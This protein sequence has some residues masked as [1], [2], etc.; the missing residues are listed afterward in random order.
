M[1][2]KEAWSIISANLALLYSIRKELLQRGEG[3]KGYTDADLEAEV[4]CFKA[5]QEM[6]ERMKKDGSL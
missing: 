4:V 6:Q 1:T 2:P 3:Y 5:L